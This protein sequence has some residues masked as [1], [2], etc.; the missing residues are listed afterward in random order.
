MQ[1]TIQETYE[2]LVEAD[3]LDKALE[4]HEKFMEDGDNSHVVSFTQNYTT[5]LD[6]DGKEI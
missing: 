1:Y 6:N 5:V 3:S 2:Y 4:A